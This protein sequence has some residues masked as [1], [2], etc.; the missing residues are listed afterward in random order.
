MRWAAVLREG[1]RA[2]AFRRR[3]ERELAE[4]LAF[5]LEMEAEKNR[6]AGM[7]AAEARR[8]ARI[9]FGGVDRTVEE[10]REAR[11]T[12]WLHDL[13]A[14]LRF[15]L[16]TLRRSPGFTAAALLTLALGLGANSAMFGLVDGILLRPLPYPD[17]D[18]L[19]RLHQAAPEA[20]IERD[21]LSPVD[22]A[23][24]RRS[25]RSFAAMAAFVHFPQILTGRGEP[26]EIGAD[27]VTE[28]YFRVLGT[29]VLL[30]RPLT[31]DDL[32]TAA[33][34]AVI[35]ERLWRIRFA[36]DRRAIGTTALLNGEAYTVVG[37]MP[38]SFCFSSPKTELWLP[39]STL[40]AME[41]GPR[42][43]ENR[44]L[45]GVAR[46]APG[47]TVERAEAE[48]SAVA[49]RLAADHPD[50]NAGWDRA[51]VVSLR[52]TLVGAVE[53]ALVVVLA[54]VGFILL[55]AC[56]NLANL[57][58]ARG[59]ARSREMAVR[60]ALGPPRGRLVRQLGTESLLLALLGCA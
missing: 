57:L 49:A 45:Q 26:A 11:G 48:L 52:D 35:G 6:A 13:A 33:T 58:L 5:H 27:F 43:R 46:L 55:I 14:D 8:R 36:G 60:T 50:T 2:L 25:T 56:V 34:N 22:F 3:E 1:F 53:G 16:R 37:V 9:A 4:E 42:T 15:A 39:Y 30:G 40:D 12:A 38:A 17:A 44:H 21:R 41:I 59:T 7:D 54:V 23:D 28:D 19:V 31:A 51:A 18:R 20:W 47:A 24:W 32:R 10:V 29:P